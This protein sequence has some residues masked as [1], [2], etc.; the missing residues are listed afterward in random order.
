MLPAVILLAIAPALVIFALGIV[1]RIVS[2]Q[3]V[4]SPVVQYTRARGASVLHDALLVEADRRAAA[5]VIVDLAVSRRIRIIANETKREPIGIELQPGAPLTGDELA[6]LEALFGPEHTS[7]RLRRFSTDRR[8]LSARLKS[9]VRNADYALARA[10]LVAQRRMAWPGTTL[11]VLAYLGMLVEAL[12]LVIT[13]GSG[14]WPALIATLAALAVTI[15][16]IV[17]T[18]ASWR[19]FLP[20]ARERREH[21]DGLRQYLVL[22]EADRMRVLQSPTGAQLIPVP[23]TT[24]AATTAPADT[25]PAAASGP[26]ARFHLHEKLL[27]YAVLFGVERDWIA[28]LKLDVQ[29]LERTNVDT[30]GDLVSGTA[31][32]AELTGHLAQLIVLVDDVAHL[33]V[34]LGDLVD[35]SGGLV[36]LADGVGSVLGSLD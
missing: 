20:A 16:T 36:D 17:V 1:A 33:T 26:L 30:L 9:V 3:P 24:D 11:T 5:A 28:T 4:H 27:P 34:A 19:R 32:L 2:R 25:S 21:L 14:D 22:A 35:V 10:G 6:V 8:A 31:D 12:L 29:T 18:P 23:Q 15:A 13:L 7:T